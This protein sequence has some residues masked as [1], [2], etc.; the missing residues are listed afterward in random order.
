M[1]TKKTALIITDGTESI[2]KLADVIAASLGENRV[3][4]LSASRLAGTDMLSADAVFIGCEEPNPASFA[5]LAELLRH[6]NLAGRP[7]GLFSFRS[8]KA[9]AYLSDLVHDSELALDREILF[10]SDAGGVSKWAE[11]IAGKS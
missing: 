1:E 2:Q 6:I 10:G 11:R 5:Y 9:A 3:T 4:I 8:K 7:C